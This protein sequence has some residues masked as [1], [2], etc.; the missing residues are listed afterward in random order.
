[1]ISVV[2][3]SDSAHPRFTCGRLTI[4][5]AAIAPITSLIRALMEKLSTIG[6]TS[7]RRSAT[8]RTRS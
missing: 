6:E 2:P 8:W 3:A 5:S 1:M 7:R 4:S